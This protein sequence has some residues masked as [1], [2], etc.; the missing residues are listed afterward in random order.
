[1]RAPLVECLH[2]LAELKAAFKDDNKLDIC[3]PKYKLYIKGL[4]LDDAREKV[5]KIVEASARSRWA[6]E[7]ITASFFSSWAQA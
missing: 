2:I 7:A 6:R 4:S 1:M 3:L 5:R